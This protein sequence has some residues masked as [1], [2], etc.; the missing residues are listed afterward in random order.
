[1]PILLYLMN[2]VM[3][4]YSLADEQMIREE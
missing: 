3:S 1:M 2:N 4:R